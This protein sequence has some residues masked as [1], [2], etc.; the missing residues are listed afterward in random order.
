MQLY[1]VSSDAVSTSTL[2]PRIWGEGVPVPTPGFVA[3]ARSISAPASAYY[4][5]VAAQAQ[6]QAQGMGPAVAAAAPSS[7]GMAATAYPHGYRTHHVLAM[8]LTGQPSQFTAA[9]AP[10]Y[11]SAPAFVASTMH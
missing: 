8:P 4:D 9:E 1:V 7:A 10:R 6:A 11:T 2:T 5:D 3:P